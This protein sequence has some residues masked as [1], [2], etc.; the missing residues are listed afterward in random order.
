MCYALLGAN[1]DRVLIGACNPMLWPIWGFFRSDINLAD[2]RQVDIPGSSDISLGPF[3][4]GSFALCRTARAGGCPFPYSVP[5]S[6][7]LDRL[8]NRVHRSPGLPL[9]S[10]ERP[11]EPPLGVGVS[12]LGP[13]RAIM[14]A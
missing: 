8:N 12:A 9:T 14:A 10:S 5:E 13:M 2:V 6:A 7:I 11:L 3:T 4:T 1:A